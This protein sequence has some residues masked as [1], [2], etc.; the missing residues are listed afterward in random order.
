VFHARKAAGKTI[1]LVTHDMATV[2]SMCHRA[3]LIEEG[4]IKYLGDP[5]STALEYYRLNFA[6]PKDDLVIDDREPTV[7]FNARTITATLRDRSGAAVENVEQGTPIAIDVVLEA[8]RGL[9]CPT[10]AFHV[11]NDDGMVVFGFDTSLDEEVAPG[12]RMRLQG[13]I[14]NRLVPGRYYLDCWVRQT[15]NERT[16]AV[17]GLRLLA[18]VVYGTASRDGVIIVGAEITASREEDAGR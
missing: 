16:I 2:Q 7:D 15:E 6:G 5:D 14:E 18:F 17:Q 13:T 4:E 1:V 3:M 8:A 11:R 9:R 10:F 12:G